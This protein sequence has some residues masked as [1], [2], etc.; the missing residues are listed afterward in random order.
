MRS[1][2]Q[3]SPVLWLHAPTRGVSPLAAPFFSSQAEPFSRRRD[4]S[5]RWWCLLAFGEYLFVFLCASLLFVRGVILN[6]L[7][8]RFGSPFTPCS[9][10]HGVACFDGL[11]YFAKAVLEADS[12]NIRISSFGIRVANVGWRCRVLVGLE[13]L[14][15]LGDCSPL[16][17]IKHAEDLY[18]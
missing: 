3:A 7:C 11:A 5:G 6:P 13:E 15:W 4:M 14:M 10:E 1:L 16:P 18:E 9:C 12:Q 17:F 2:I 8:L